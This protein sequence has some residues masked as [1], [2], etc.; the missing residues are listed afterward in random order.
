MYTSTVIEIA[1]RDNNIKPR[2]IYRAKK[3]RGRSDAA[4]RTVD[5]DC[6]IRVKSNS[7]VCLTN[8]KKMDRGRQIRC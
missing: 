4:L 6:R 2:E 8:V 1:V 5:D 7:C 3:L